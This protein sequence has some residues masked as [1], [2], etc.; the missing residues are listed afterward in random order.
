M[1]VLE[2]YVDA[3]QRPAPARSLSVVSASNLI[4]RYGQGDG[5]TGIDVLLQD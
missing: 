2:Q 4:K 1:S 3:G 5:Y